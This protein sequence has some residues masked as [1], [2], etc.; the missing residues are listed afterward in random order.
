MTKEQIEQKVKQIIIDKWLVSEEI[1]P[2]DK[3]DDFGVDS[4]DRVEFI[5]AL[6]SEFKIVIP[7]ND[8]E[9]IETVV[10]T[11]SYIEKKITQPDESKEQ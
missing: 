3:F 5:M 9:E 8:A 4:L 7:D 11:I 2:E 1:K 10:A 6:E